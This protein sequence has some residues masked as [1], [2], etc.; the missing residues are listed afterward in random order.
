VGKGVNPFESAKKMSSAGAAKLKST[1]ASARA[2]LIDNKKIVQ[3]K[4]NQSIKK[5]K[6]GDFIKRPSSKS[7]KAVTKTKKVQSPGAAK[8]KSSSATINNKTKKRRVV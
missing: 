4:I 1:S 2:K 7:P 5:P 6:F 3:S 8:P